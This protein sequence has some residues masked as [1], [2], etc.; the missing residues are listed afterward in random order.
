MG[1]PHSLTPSELPSE[2]RHP[3]PYREGENA[4]AVN[5]APATFRGNSPSLQGEGWQGAAGSPDG[6]GLEPIFKAGCAVAPVTSWRFYDSAYTERFMRTPQENPDGY[7]DCPIARA[8]NIK[9]A[10]LL[11]HGTA[12][13]NVHFR[14]FTEM[15]EALVQADVPF[16]CQIYRNRNHSIYGGNTRKHLLTR[17]L[18]HFKENL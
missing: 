9:G 17:I 2:L 4:P 10:L 6:E 14:N 8:A 12:D 16:D 1:E 11:I 3:S 18:R 7:N 5:D 15:S 13:D